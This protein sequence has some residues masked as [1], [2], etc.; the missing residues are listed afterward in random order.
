MNRETQARRF[1][2]HLRQPFGALLIKPASGV[3][4]AVD[5]KRVAADSMISV[6]FQ[7]NV[8]LADLLDNVC[9]IAVL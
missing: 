1:I 9:M 6:H 8:L 3:Q 4:C 5:Y 7:Q 2:A